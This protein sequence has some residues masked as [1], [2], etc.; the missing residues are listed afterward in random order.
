M[1]PRLPKRQFLLIPLLLA[2]FLLGCG[3]DPTHPDNTIAT[4]RAET[5][6]L[7]EKDARN[8]SSRVSNVSYKLDFELDGESVNFTARVDIGFDLADPTTSLTLDFV[9]GDVN[10]IVVN[11]TETEVDYNGYYI[12]LSPNDLIQGPNTLAI[13][14]THPYSND[15]SGLY[16]FRDPIDNNDYLYTDFEPYDANR[17]FPCFDQPD[18]KATYATTVTVPSSWEVISIVQE[19]EIEVLG[20]RK[21]WV[22][23]ESAR[24]STYIY[25]LHAGNYVSWHENAGDIPLRLF[26]RASMADYVRTDDWFTPTKE[27]FQF[28]QTYF[29]V[30]YPFGKYDQL[31]V[32]H[33]NSGAMENLGAVTYSERFLTRGKVTRAQRRSLASVI[34]HEMAHMWFGNLVTMD[35]WNGL[36]LNEAFAT[37]M[38]NL[39]L[40]KATEFHEVNLSAFRSNTAAYR[41]DERDTTHPIEQPTPNTDAAFAIFDAITY[42]KGSAVLSQLR[43]LVGPDKL[44]DGVS[45]YLK[46]HSYANT[47]IDD[48]LNAI[49]ESAGM[50]LS[51]WAANWLN[52]SGT[53]SVSVEYTCDEDKLSTLILNQSAPAEWPTLRK[54][55]TQLGLYTFS[56]EPV[57][58]I[59]VPVT[60]VGSRTDVPIRTVPC[61]DAI[62]ANHGNW[63]FVRVE[64][65]KSTMTKL[66]RHINEFDDPLQRSMLWYSMYEMVLYQRMSPIEFIHFT[67]RSLPGEPNDDVKRQVLGNMLSAWS[68]VRRLAPEET[69]RATAE[70]IEE[71]VWERLLASESGSDRQLLLFDSYTSVASSDAGLA[72]LA[73][74]LIEGSVP[75]GI[76][77]DQDRRW[78]VLQTLS[79]HDYSDTTAL[80]EN[81]IANDGTDS[82]RLR[83]LSVRA[84]RPDQ[85]HREHVVGLLLDPP[86]ELTVYEARAYARGVFPFEQQAAQLQVT[87]EVFSRLQELSDNVDSRYHSAILSGL[88]GSICDKGYLKQLEDVVNNGSTLHP[89]M[90]K[91][92]LDMRF[93]V[94]RC[95]DIGEAI[96]PT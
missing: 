51:D 67:V 72:R 14:F 47:T 25:A 69:V 16:R 78:G 32:P 94:R 88:L 28:F 92:L 15:G 46:R 61:P 10:R 18:L 13:D 58:Q 76:Q 12:T 65:D 55:Q 2:L 38:A 23:P 48:F 6:N 17:L 79:S 75:D 56:T 50:D 34:M 35:W 93:Q 29:D 84:A 53:N 36:W 70:L 22:F 96:T 40:E 11:D 68:Y 49:A 19:S 39:A 33:F 77:F 82:G 80:L 63:D 66:G 89:S 54:H 31:I 85:A 7:A 26:A 3:R 62:Y 4:A 24:I 9:G 83:A 21:R 44:R 60:Y 95:L 52:Q 90:R 91:R 27:G 73:G 43:H 64:L 5:S 45:S 30:P 86:P 41:A 81:E 57:L 74:F 71:F 8:R 1:K 87:G 20:E 59:V 37:F 42:N